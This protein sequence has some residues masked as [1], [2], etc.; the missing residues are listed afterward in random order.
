MLAY[1]TWLMSDA[2]VRTLI[3]MFV[4]H[5][6]L[7]EWTTARQARYA[8]DLKLAAIYK[9]MAGGVLLALAAL[10]VGASW[11]HHGWA[12]LLPFIVLWIAAPAIAWRISLPPRRSGSSRSPQRML[13]SFV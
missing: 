2:I 5:R 12:V 3:R 4:T 7:L 10:V 8:V 6:H 11:G 1:Q 9:R 13:G